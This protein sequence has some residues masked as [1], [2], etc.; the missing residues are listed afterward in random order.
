MFRGSSVV[1]GTKAYFSPMC[2]ADRKVY[3]C[4]LHIYSRNISWT[5]LPK[6]PHYD[7]GLA[8]VN[9]LLTAVGGYEQE[10]HMSEPTNSLLTLSEANSSGKWE[11]KLQ[12]MPTKRRLPAVASME[13]V[14]IVAGGQGTRNQILSTVEVM[15][16]R[17]GQWSTANALL[18]PLTHASIAVCDNNLYIAGGQ[19]DEGP[20]QATFCSQ[21]QNLSSSIRGSHALN[22]S[23]WQQIVNTPS[24][25]CTLV[26][27]GGHLLALGG[28][29]SYKSCSQTIYTYV[30]GYNLWA[31]AGNMRH[32]RS[33]TLAAVL[34]DGTLVA[35]GGFTKRNEVTNAAEVIIS[36]P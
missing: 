13:H 16:T 27:Q 33:A 19:T 36:I 25:W 17:S 20:T 4:Q 22:L 29:D 28:Q 31:T 8:S 23:P 34:S 9:G 6:C 10:Y 32:K 1:H 24:L 7:F 12:P 2:T 3:V 15:N 11:Q 21:L 30:P 18:I 14:L 35:V 5:Q 26:S